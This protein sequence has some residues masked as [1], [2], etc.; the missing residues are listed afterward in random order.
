MTESHHTRERLWRAVEDARFRLDSARNAVKGLDPDHGRIPSPD[1][2]YAYLQALRAETLA[3]RSYLHALQEYHAAL[4]PTSQQAVEETGQTEDALTPRER[5]VLALVASGK[6]S[7][8]IARE[9][10]ISF[11]TSVCHRYRI[12]KKLHAHNT[13]DLTRAAIRMG[14]IEV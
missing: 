10:G 11:R 9:L 13:A 2:G 4:S 1:G 7:K 5:E 8:Q 6:S 14:L 3:V 12:Q